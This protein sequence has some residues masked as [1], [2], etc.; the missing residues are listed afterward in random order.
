M[1]CPNCGSSLPDNAK[2]CTN[3]GHSMP[4]ASVQP[5]AAVQ[6]DPMQYA[7]P[8]QPVQPMQPAQPVQYI[9]PKTASS[10]PFDSFLHFIIA[11]VA[12][13]ALI[14]AIMNLFNLYKVRVS[15]SVFSASGPVSDVARESAAV[16]IGNLLYGLTNL[17]IVGVGVLYFIKKMFNVPVYDKIVG[18]MF[19]PLLSKFVSGDG[20]ATLIGAVG[21]AIGT[22]QLFFYLIAGD[23]YRVGMHW[24]SWVALFLYSGLAVLDIFLFSRKQKN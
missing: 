13:L 3:C 5:A 7:Q 14:L 23:G 2:F 24:T 21:T 18:K 11:G 17:A 20:V 22:L 8:V 4:T 16:L 10:N 9:Q 19:S 1:F 12:T 6:P 15:V